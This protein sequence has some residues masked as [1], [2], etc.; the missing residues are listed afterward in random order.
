MRYEEANNLLTQFDPANNLSKYPCKS[1][2]SLQLPHFLVRGECFRQCFIII[3]VRLDRVDN[4][5]APNI[6]LSDE[7]SFPI[8]CICIR[9]LP[10]KM[11]AEQSIKFKV[12][13]QLNKQQKKYQTDSKFYVNL[14]KLDL[15][16][17]KE[18]ISKK[19][20]LSG[21]SVCRALIY[22]LAMYPPDT[23]FL[24]KMTLYL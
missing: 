7:L 2:T 20:F 3:I 24:Q 8:Q 22:R 10:R 6:N 11:S 23:F 1:F 4:K 17:I 12:L 13:D 19:M 5:S 21:T 18:A 9:S 16:K 14:F 15:R